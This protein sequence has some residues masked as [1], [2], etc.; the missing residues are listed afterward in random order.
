MRAVL[1]VAVVLLSACGPPASKPP[2]FTVTTPE[3][4][5]H[6]AACPYLLFAAHRAKGGDVEEPEN[7]VAAARA[8]VDAG[9]PMLEIDTRQTADGVVVLSHDDTLDRVTDAELRF[10]GRTQV[11]AL[12][13]AEVKSL[14]VEHPQ[15][16]GALPDPDRC[17]I[18][19]L[20]DLL[21]VS[22]TVTFFVDFKGGDAAAT[23]A[24]FASKGALSRVLFFDSSLDVLRQVHATQPTVELLPRIHNAAEAAQVVDTSGLPVRWVHGDPGYV[25]EAEA[26]LKPKGV[27]FYADI[28]SLDA[29]FLAVSTRSEA[30][31]AAHYRTAVWPRLRTFVKDGLDG[32]GTE[33]SAPMLRELYPDGWGVARKTQ[34][35]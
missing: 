31:R 13:L 6:D 4:C 32:A 29:E 33:Y 7:S 25:A 21:A 23:L 3:A 18:A 19:T 2:E 34:G 9:V 14:T 20:E 17:R 30:E 8:S 35:P 1:P 24:V 16:T 22:D 11:S 26:A 12:T 5:L 27:R 28:W 10:P 15:C